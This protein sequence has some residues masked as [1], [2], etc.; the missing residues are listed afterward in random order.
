VTHPTRTQHRLRRYSLAILVVLACPAVALGANEPPNASFSYSPE[1]PR[2]GQSI[3]F[4][5]SSCDPDGDLLRQA[6]DL[7]GDGAYDDAEG[8]IVTQSFPGSGARTVGLEVTA[9][10]GATDTQRRTVMVNTEYALPRPDSDRL[11]SPFPVIRLAGQLTRSGARVKVLSVL[12]APVCAFVRVTCRGKSCPARR[13]SGYMR[14]HGALRFRRFERRLRAGT[15]LTVRV[16]KNDLIGKF[17]QFRIR[18]DAAP[19][20]RDRCLRPG[21]RRGTSCPRD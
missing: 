3:Q 5:S 1:D 6:W 2:A 17:T 8:P 21:Q 14:R 10:G 9:A 11:M 20:R 15:V 19:K 4:E 18:K 13:A 16:S 12:R 7:D